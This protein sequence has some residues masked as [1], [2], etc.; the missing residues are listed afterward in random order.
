MISTRKRPGI[1][2]IPVRAFSWRSSIQALTSIILIWRSIWTNPNPG[3]HGYA[4]DVH[5]WN[6]V[7]NNNNP[8]DDFYHGTHVSGILGAAGN[9]GVG[10]AGTT[11]AVQIMPLKF[12][13]NTG[14]GATSDAVDAINYAKKYSVKIMSNS[15]GSYDYSQSLKDAIDSANTAGILFVAAAGN[16][17]LDTDSDPNYPAD[18]TSSNIIS[19]AA[20]DA[21][22]QLANFSNYGSSTVQIAAPGVGIFS[23]LPTVAT[24]AMSE[25]ELPTSYGSLDGTSMATPFVSGAAALALAQNPS[26]SVSALKSL[27]IQR[28]DHLL[29]LEGKD[30]EAGR[31][32]LYNVV[33]PN[34]VPGPATLS[35]SSIPLT[36]PEGNDNGYANPGE[37]IDL[38]PTIV[39][40]G[41]QAATGVTVQIVS[42]QSTATV[43]TN[44]QSLSTLQPYQPEAVKSPYRVQLSSSLAD[45][46]T[47]TFDVVISGTGLTTVHAA[48]SIIVSQIKPVAEA[49]VSFACGEIKADPTRNL[50]YVLD[51][52]DHRLLAVNTDSGQLA[53]SIPLDDLQAAGIGPSI[54]GGMAVSSDGSTLYVALTDAQKIQMVS[55]PG[56][57]PLGSL[58]LS[59]APASLVVGVNNRLY[60]APL[61]TG[62]IY[63]VNTSTGQ[64]N[65]IIAEP[66]ST[67]G[68]P[69]G[70]LLRTSNDGTKLYIAP[71]NQY[72]YQ[73]DY[74]YQYDVSGS[75]AVSLG[76]LDY[77]GANL[78]DLAADDQE[79]RLYSTNYYTSG[80]QVTDT[81]DSHFGTIYP[82]GTT[83]GAAIALLPNSS[84]LYGAS[85]SSI[86]GNIRK[87]RRSDGTSLG[88]YYV[89]TGGQGIDSRA[90]ALT[91][92]GNLV[93]IKSTPY[94]V[95][96]IGSSTLNVTTPVASSPG[97]AVQ[98]SSVVLTDPEGNGDGNPNS[99]EVIHIAPTF[100]N[101]GSAAATN[102]TIGVSAG[103]GS[104]VISS[105]T[106]TL[107]IIASLATAGTS[108]YF[109]VQLSSS[110]PSGTE[111]PLTF[112]A[113]WGTGQSAQFNYNIIVQSTEI[114]SVASSSVQFGEILA[115][116]QRDI[117]YVVD[118]TYLRLL[119]FDTDAGHVDSTTPIGGLP[120]VNGVPP[121]PGL[122][123]ESV[124]G[125]KLYLA[126][127]G[128][129]IIQVFSLPSMVSTAQWSYSFSPE[130]L[131]TDALGRIYCV[132]NDYHQA[133]V[134]I[135]GTSGAVLSETGQNYNF[136]PSYPCLLHRNLAGTEVYI[137]FDG[138]IYRYSTTGSGA[139]TQL[140]A[141]T[142]G[143]DSIDDFA[144]DEKDSL[145]YVADGSPFLSLWHFNGGSSTD[146]PL[147]PF[148]GVA[149]SYLATQP[150]VLV[151]GNGGTSSSVQS[152]QQS[153]AALLQVYPENAANAPTITP[154]GLA[155]TPNGLT[156][157][158]EKTF[159]SDPDSVDGYDYDLGM[160]N[161]EVNLDIPTSTSI[162]LQKV[163]IT[164]PAPG[165]ADGY[166]HP[167]QT[168]QISPTFINFSNAEISSLTVSL[169]T[170]DPLATVQSANTEVVGNIGSYVSFA[171]NPAFSV[172]ISPN[173][174]D[175][176]SIQFSFQITYN[177]GSQL[178]IPYTAYVAGNTYAL[179]SANFQVG[180]MV[181]DSTRNLSYVIDQTNQR[182]LAINTDTGAITGSA[183]LISTPSQGQLAVSVDGNF[184]Y[185]SL[186]PT[187]QIEVLKLP[188]LKESDLLQLPFQTYNMVTG[189]DG[190]IYA[191]CSTGNSNAPIVEVQPS[192]GGWNY[193]G[194]NSYYSD[195]LIQ[196]NPDHTQFYVAPTGIFGDVNVSEYVYG[197]TGYGLT[198]LIPVD[199][200]NPQNLAANS[201]TNQLYLAQAPGIQVHNLIDGLNSFWVSPSNGSAALSFIGGSNFVYQAPSYGGVIRRF[202]VVDGVPSAD[203]DVL[204]GNYAFISRGLAQT[205]N[206]NL[207]FSAYAY[208]Q[209]GYVYQLGLIGASTLNL[210]APPN[211]P[212]IN[213]GS[214]QTVIMSAGASLSAATAGSSSNLPVTWTQVGGPSGGSVIT[215]TS[216][217]TASVAFNAPGT[218]EFQGTVTDAGLTG[219][220]SVTVTVLSNPPTITVAATSP[221]AISIGTAGAFTLTRSGSTTSALQV[222]FALSGTAQAGSDYL[223][224]G[225]TANFPAGQSTVNV[226]IDSFYSTSN[227]TVTLTL[228]S[229]TNYFQPGN[230][231]SATVVLESSFLNSAFAIYN[232]GQS[233]VN[234]SSSSPIVLT[235]PTLPGNHSLIAYTWYFNSNEV[236]DSYSN[237]YSPSS[238]Q[239]G[240]YT[241]YE[242]A[243][244]DGT[245]AE[246]SWNT[247]LV[248]ASPAMIS[249]NA[250]NSTYDGTGKTATAITTPSGLAV[251]VT[252]NGG[253]DPP[254]NAGTYEVVAT[255][256]GGGY[257][258]SAEATMTI[259]PA[260]ATV[261]L[262]NL[263]QPYDGS[264]L[265][266]TATTVPL[267]LGVNF[268]YNGS[269]TPPTNVG[270]Y[271]VV[272]TV[273][274]QNY[275]GSATGTF[276]VTSSNPKATVTL[277]GIAA[278]YDGTPKTVT[279]T[280]NP[281]GLATTI[282]YNGSSF[283]PTAAG[284]YT[285]SAII[286]NSYF[287]GSTTG[288]LVINPGPASL[289]FQNLEVSY[290]G[291]PQPVTVT[292][293][294]PGLS[295]S[296]LYA[297]KSVVPTAIGSYSVSGTITDPNYTG[298]STGTYV[299]LAAPA[300][301]TLGSLSV[302][303]NGKSQSATATTVPP[304]L[305]VKF[306]YNGSSKSP[307]SAGTYS[308]V[309]TVSSSNYAGS[310][311]GT[312]VIAPEPC[313]ITFTNLTFTY[314]GS[315]QKVK[316]TTSPSAAGATITYGGSPTAP[317]LIGT[318]A[319]VATASSANYTG[320][321]T[322]TETINPVAPTVSG[323]GTT[324]IGL[325]SA[326][327]KVK[328]N[329]KGSSTTVTF[330]YGTTSSY[331]MTST[332]Q[333][334]PAGTSSVEVMASIS[335]LQ[336]STKY[337]FRAVAT[338]G[339]GTKDGSDTAF[340]TAKATMVSEATAASV[341]ASASKVQGVVS[342]HGKDT[343]AYFEY[344]T[345][346]SF[347]WQT[348]VQDL[349]NGNSAVAVNS[350]LPNLEPKT[351]YY[352]RLVTVNSAG[353][354]YGATS[355][356]TTLAF[357]TSL[358]Q[359][360]GN[361]APLSEEAHGTY[362]SFGSP[363]LNDNDCLAFLA[364]LNPNSEGISSQ[365]KTGIWSENSDGIL[366]LVTQTG[367]IAP[368]TDDIFLS[369]GDPIYNN[370]QEVAF[371]GFCGGSENSSTAGIWSDI[372]GKLALVARE[373]SQ[374]PGCPIGQTIN[375]LT[376]LAL[377]DKGQ[378]VFS[379]KLTDNV[380]EGV[381]SSNDAAIWEGTP[382]QIRPVL[383][384]G[385]MVSTK[386]VASI[387]SSLPVERYVGG[388]SRGISTSTGDL[389]CA[390]S[391]T[392]DTNGLVKVVEAS[393][394]IVAVTGD[395]AAGI[396]GAE[397][398][399]FGSP[400]INAH[401]RV[402]FAAMLAEDI[403]GVSESNNLGI[404]AD[405]A[406]GNRH[407]V[408]RSG[409][410]APGTNATF[411]SFSDPV[412]NE[413]EVTCFRATLE[414][415]NGQA[416]SENAVGIW[417]NSKG[418]LSLVARQGDQANGLPRGITFKDFSAIALANS[419][420]G[421]D[422][423][424]AFLLATLN[425][426][427]SAGVTA[428]NNLG[429]WAVDHSGIL[430]PIVRTGDLLGGKKVTS[431]LFLPTKKDVNEQSRSFAASNGAFIYRAS[432]SDGSAGIYFVQF[433]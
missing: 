150:N 92:N 187:Q 66:G 147:S 164:D 122:M 354:S 262:S 11:W 322:A 307:T 169:V 118:K 258:G 130:S 274:N 21:N 36:D 284:T 29:Q 111:I 19:V 414:Q 96:L 191:T 3:K 377:S 323:E 342:P 418:T 335:G 317:T 319:V 320:S 261:T 233:A 208:A 404:W 60:A 329:P 341:G 86:L 416:T 376:S 31:L 350:A 250:A 282:T 407:L 417:S 267:G 220:D 312:M 183:K 56:I 266:V 431:L 236:A 214:A 37:I 397:F 106:Q 137:G 255:V 109:R 419:G 143:G 102:V 385:D 127:P 346:S 269:S 394:S 59:F 75:S 305:T 252:Y 292:T 309:G 249:L 174:P 120:L 32:N 356:L 105:T 94:V 371:R 428:A 133:L 238:A 35:L 400:E 231:A 343:S 268:T 348:A 364:N 197:S 386:T 22:D 361:A 8:Q 275:Q 310:A 128:S 114:P 170:S 367:D 413:N 353:A 234:F 51:D 196:A 134:Q 26:L 264:P 366:E 278:I 326:T 411:L 405:D 30:T 338:N 271:T 97:S 126:L 41:Q 289:T 186:S 429:I 227:L 69:A 315:A 104:A 327:L 112:T 218:Y 34:W 18:Y 273:A 125:S 293:S 229:G 221:V 136:S 204:S 12:L 242:Y 272:G 403:A 222:S 398:A 90:L 45:N 365:N 72:L 387:T 372:G 200:S 215:L 148:Y 370:S 163:S 225:L 432:F 190:N 108:T 237:T 332:I 49:P 211:A 230:P 27:I 54:T 280:T 212:S 373:G 330:Q 46:T 209:N 408:A 260:A 290:T 378:I 175:G 206:G 135:D 38:T 15:W 123:A 389:V 5:G 52:T 89:G 91:P 131:A 375:S 265:A 129:G 226:P 4:N 50:V 344:G 324:T 296:V 61:Q 71:S 415:A 362:A 48:A 325:S 93:Y 298:S 241:V 306:T 245:T 321:A 124:D 363:V 176:H 47:L 304:G 248:S 223:N 144:V 10:I 433:P 202:D 246:A 396:P 70:T 57:S 192:T 299:I 401:D 311:T 294:P 240:T 201:S 110:L 314:N 380:A 339:G 103:T 277:S 257:A 279:A 384:L 423:G 44:S 313:T 16:D 207:L 286:N 165:S 391:F 116:Q 399:S 40:L 244:D 420:G 256:N 359:E 146:W 302:T 173:A 73:V 76:K 140:S 291:S 195:S 205:P 161:G 159:M 84:V 409:T 39:N 119:L 239:S 113:T 276:T 81:N 2:S 142:F 7:A 42:N 139:P 188:D 253:S 374:A 224:P 162:S 107:G 168:I 340:T 145:Y 153:T 20:T 270:S 171:A 421:T 300:T 98:L 316:A 259:A 117:V 360:S 194:S 79:G 430:Q 177:N 87:F 288:K 77:N 65:Q 254:V 347:G 358:V 166:V 318:Y 28:A 422:Q 381:S 85:G 184:L 23:T 243:F 235:A 303:Y 95:G 58:P 63:E 402:A 141:T 328:V 154:R 285:I 179:A 189:V 180:S 369:L 155:T 410:T 138:V 88:D 219:S 160:I 247:Q 232:F 156:V 101:A 333:T 198:Q 352:Y 351:T 395:E 181:P 25:E 427:S 412:Y 17:S 80:V 331:G 152:F 78:T 99:G 1:S 182:V 355:S 55:L 13:D 6:F 425:T 287:T 185:V 193:V 301:I 115:D 172:A 68:F 203:Y 24:E 334:V 426:N 157:F 199:L 121:P 151:A 62:D 213:V 392:D 67:T 388:Q 251:A 406:S 345:S 9:N 393:P 337:H 74:I 368:G 281:P 178:T 83:P 217:S 390:A 82:L 33:N 382:T 379:G 283:P 357:D 158:I 43:L 228:P 295:V 14:S 210:L 100:F 383:R 64:N 349:G 149:V 424:G 132:T 263:V 167:G 308:V 336:A 216:N 297:K 53:A